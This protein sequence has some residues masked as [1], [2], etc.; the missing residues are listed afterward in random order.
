MDIAIL[1]AGN[2]GGTLGEGWAGQGHEVMFGVQD[3]AD[4]KIA[5]LLAR[6]GQNASAGTVAEAAAFGE[7]VALT[8]PWGAVRDVLE[9][10][11]DLTGKILL[12]C[13]NP[14][15]TA[16]PAAAPLNPGGEQVAALASGARVVKI[17]NTTGWENMANPRYGNEGVTMFYAGNDEAAKTVASQ[18]ATDLGFDAIDVGPLSFAHHLETLAQLWGQLAYGQKMGR[19]IAF[20]LM[21]R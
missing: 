9:A 14:N 19:S 15:F 7:V 18:L 3:P 11:G 20:K 21:R 4:L 1:G 17:F 12:D 10:A 16:D 5:D 6:A 13:T 2:V 8:V